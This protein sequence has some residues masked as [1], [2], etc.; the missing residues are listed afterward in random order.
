MKLLSGITLSAFPVVAWAAQFIPETGGHLDDDAN[1]TENRAVCAIAK[2]Q[3]GPLT[4]S[5]ANASLP[6]SAGTLNYWNYAYTNDFGVGN[7]LD[8]HSK[9][10]IL[11]RGAALYHVSGEIA[12][13]SAI[14]PCLPPSS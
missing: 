9:A 6:G 10:L 7:V 13:G 3:S 11:D 4:I 8:L 14:L 2:A 1:W 5:T 12:A